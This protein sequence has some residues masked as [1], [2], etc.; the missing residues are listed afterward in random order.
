MAVEYPGYGSYEGEPEAKTII[1][2][3]EIVFDFLTAEVGI[4]PKIYWFLV[5]LLDQA[6]QHI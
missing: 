4:N 3:A 5:D 1:E 6:Q 2:D